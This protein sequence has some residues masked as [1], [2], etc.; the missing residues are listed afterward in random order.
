MKWA[1]RVVGDVIPLPVYPSINEL[2]TIRRES[3][4][5]GFM[6]E[7]AQVHCVCVCVCVYVCVCVCAC[8]R[9]CVFVRVCVCV[10]VYVMF[11]FVH[12][13]KIY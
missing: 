1:N 5:V 13:F 7:N 4:V 2:N 11:L 3:A 9:A 10:F 12:V 6:G 8:V